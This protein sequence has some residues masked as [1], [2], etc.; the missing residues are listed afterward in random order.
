MLT[1]IP[2]FILFI[3]LC[4]NVAY[5]LIFSIAGLF[6]KSSKYSSHPVKKSIA[7]LIPSYKEDSI[8][9]ETAKHALKQQYPHNLFDVFVIADGLLPN[10]ITAL[11]KLHVNVIPVKFEKSTKARS[12]KYAL[13]LLPHNYDISLILDADNIIGSFCLE[14]INHA[15]NNG[16]NAVQLHRT[17]KNMNTS[18]AILDAASEEI[19]NHIFRKGHRRLGLSSALIGSGMAINHSMFKSIMSSNDIEDNPGEDRE[20]NLELLRRDIICEYIDDE[21]VLDEKVQ[22]G[23]V[24]EKQ[25]TRWISAQMHYANKFW[26]KE[27]KTT[28]C[29]GP[30]YIDLA[31]QTILLPRIILLVLVSIFFLASVILNV[32]SNIKLLFSPSAWMVL[33]LGTILSFILAIYG[34]VSLKVFF[35]ALTSLPIAILSFTRAL[36]KSNSNKHEFIHTPK[37]ITETIG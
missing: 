37:N 13:R 31:I 34:T 22:T 6:T 29:S 16:Y 1:Y 5:L 36:S 10:T 15:F 28:I 25:R 30:H 4:G 35:K 33:F 3:Y 26:I 21:M 18:I 9:I 17:A 19:N 2:I 20:I 23:N 27:L 11:T 14:K 7:I 24:L 12:L 8:I 32:S